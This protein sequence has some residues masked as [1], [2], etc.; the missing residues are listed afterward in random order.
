LETAVKIAR[1]VGISAEQ[2]NEDLKEERERYRERQ[3]QKKVRRGKV[4]R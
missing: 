3:A 2:L 1:A 4:P